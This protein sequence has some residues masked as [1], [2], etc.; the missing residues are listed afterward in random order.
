MNTLKSKEMKSILITINL[1]LLVAASVIAKPL[2]ASAPVPNLTLHVSYNLP[3]GYPNKGGDHTTVGGTLYIYTSDPSGTIRNPI[4]MP[5]A[6][7]AENERGWEE[8]YERMNA[9]NMISCL[10]SL[11]YD[12]IVLDYE[13]GGNYIEHNAYLLT[14]VIS[15][16]NS[17][18]VTAQKNIVVGPSMGGL[19]A[20]YAL[21]YME[22][23]NI[24]HDTRLFISFDSP[25]DGANVPLGLQYVSRYWDGRIGGEEATKAYSIIKS[26]AA[27]EM[28]YYHIVKTL[29]T[30]IIQPDPLRTSFL[31]NLHDLGDWPMKLRKVA[32]SNGSGYGL[33]QLKSDG[34]SRLQP[35]DKILDFNEGS[36]IFSRAWAVPV[37]DVPATK[38][39][40]CKTFFDADPDD[41]TVSGTRPYDN[42]PGGYRNFNE[43]LKFTNQ[44]DADFQTFI[45]TFSAL[46]INTNENY[47]NPNADANVL[48]KTPFDAI[49]YPVENEEHVLVTAQNKNWMFNEIMPANMEISTTFLQGKAEITNVK[50]SSQ[51]RLLPGFSTGSDAD[52]RIYTQSFARCNLSAPHVPAEDE[53]VMGIESEKG[54]ERFVVYPNPASDKITIDAQGKQVQEIQLLQADGK[55]ITTVKPQGPLYEM[56]LSGLDAGMYFIRIV[57]DNQRII[58]KVILTH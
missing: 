43:K 34:V 56:D 37:P 53:V 29:E 44:A 32:I 6:F 35:G 18:K 58:K 11:G 26:F 7:D 8:L 47:Y 16:V 27:R 9:Q 30:G 28:L 5:E 20:R 14:K 48:S 52:L 19:V 42:M 4:I 41:Y 10:H 55:I 39:A 33:L 38:I 21:T 36:A 25:Q 22:N 40:R 2:V 31:Q 50:A 54:S 1:L 3:T 17:E 51:I 12:I 46:A 13:E 57:N 24:N 23:K 15:Y 45:P 49:Y